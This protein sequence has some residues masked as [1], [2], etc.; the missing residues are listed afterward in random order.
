MSAQLSAKVT[1]VG[2]SG[3]SASGKSTLARLL[4]AYLGEEKC[5]VINSDDYYLP[6]DHIP[7]ERRGLS[8]YDHPASLE[9]DLLALH[10][11]SLRKGEVVNCP[12]YD[13]SQH[14]RKKDQ[15]RGVSSRSIVIVDGALIFAVPAFRDL[16]DVRVFV[17]VPDS[18]RYQRRLSRDMRER[19]R[20]ESDIE[21]Q[22]NDTV[23]PMFEEFCKPSR[24]FADIVLDGVSLTTDSMPLIWGAIVAKI[25]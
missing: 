13:F 23:Q 22:W 17:D 25:T 20:T 3:G 11:R 1:L 5:V 15:F 8:N 19:G 9:L 16:F 21:C 24:I 18:V 12:V 4:L 10:L 14:T 6:Q 2:I 7:P